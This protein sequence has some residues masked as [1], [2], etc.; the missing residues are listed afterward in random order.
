M[1]TQKNVK[2]RSCNSANMLNWGMVNSLNSFAGRVFDNKISAIY[3]YECKNCYL[4]GKYPILKAYEYNKLYKLG[5][6]IVWS[7]SFSVLRD[8]QNY[9]KEFIERSFK[10]DNT[11]LDIGCFTG[12][13]LAALPKSISKYGVEM[14]REASSICRARN[15]QIIGN[16]LYSIKTSIR[17]DFIV[18]IDV[19]EHTSNPNAFLNKLFSILN[20]DGKIIISTGNSDNWLWRLLKNRFWYSKF[21]EH[22]SFVGMN[23][24]S[25]YCKRNKKNIERVHFFA[26]DFNNNYFI[27][28]FK[29]LAKFILL[30]LCI[31]PERF[32]NVSSDHFC[33]V[34]SNLNKNK[35]KA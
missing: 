16:N 7:N 31:N 30:I 22:I 3:I 33:F 19:I 21:P 29:K 1:S 17:F 20:P 23:W 27:N 15:L 24:L 6:A 28:K 34:I 11:V 35:F 9:V 4:V 26:H 8:D 13:L 5:S 2:C 10:K 32:S 12:D 18:A 14:S 25:L